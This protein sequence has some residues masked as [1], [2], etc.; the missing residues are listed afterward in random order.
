MGFCCPSAVRLKVTQCAAPTALLSFPTSF[1]L[2]PTRACPGREPLGKA[3]W[4]QSSA[5]LIRAAGFSAGLCSAAGP[6][7]HQCSRRWGGCPDAVPAEVSSKLL[8]RCTL[9][10]RLPGVKLRRAAAST[11]RLRSGAGWLLRPHPPAAS[12]QPCC[13]L[14]P[15]RSSRSLLTRQKAVLFIYFLGLGFCWILFRLFF[16]FL[17]KRAN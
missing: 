7:Q 11:A 13:S 12:R 5:F 14:G 2:D 9:R 1:L 10:A 3:A 8:Q 17:S 6:G 16:F 15:F 4:Q